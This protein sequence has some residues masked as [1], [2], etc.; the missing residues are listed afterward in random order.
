MPREKWQN[1]DFSK[2]AQKPLPTRK[3]INPVH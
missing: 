2:I 1:R 3:S